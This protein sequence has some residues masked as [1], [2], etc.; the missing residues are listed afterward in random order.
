MLLLVL[1]SSTTLGRRLR[2]LGLEALYWPFFSWASSQYASWKGSVRWY[3]CF[4]LQMQSWSTFE[5]SSIQI[6]LGWLGLLTGKKD[7]PQSKF[8][9]LTPKTHRY[10][11]SSASATLIIVASEFTSYWG[12]SK[13]WKIAAFNILAP[14]VM[15]FINFA[16]VKVCLPAPMI[17][18]NCSYRW[19]KYF[20]WIET[21]AGFLKGCMVL[22]T[23]FLMYVIH[24]K[25]LYPI[26]A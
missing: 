9:E 1:L 14:V 17:M 3:R 5:L 6:G 12:L 8:A 10:F 26:A 13:F 11:N 7:L 16:G 25:G 4:Q 22:G 2:S 24:A 18:R 15:L 20:G 21:V 23:G 19:L